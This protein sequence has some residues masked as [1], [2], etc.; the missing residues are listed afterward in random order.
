MAVLADE[1]EQDP[2]LA[3]AIL[4]CESGLDNTAVNS[5]VSSTTG[6]VTS[7]DYGFWQ[8]NDFYHETDAKEKG[9]DIRNPEQNLEYGFILMKESYTQSW[10]A[11]S[12]CWEKP[13]LYIKQYENQL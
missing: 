11:T 1:Y 3:L 2:N 12:G 10:K 9:F 13:M 6:E 4:N 7:H 8:I 5:N